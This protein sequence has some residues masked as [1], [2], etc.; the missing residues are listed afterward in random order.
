MENVGGIIFG[1]LFQ[2][3]DKYAIIE[4]IMFQ[5]WNDSFEEGDADAVPVFERGL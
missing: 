5:M 1:K 4:K 2:N 3:K